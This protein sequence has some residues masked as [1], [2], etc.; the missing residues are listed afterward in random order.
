MHCDSDVWSLTFQCKVTRC[1]ILTTRCMHYLWD[2]CTQL[3]GTTLINCLTTMSFN[4]YANPGYP[5]L[6]DS[7]CVPLDVPVVKGGVAM[8]TVVLSSS[9]LSFPPFSL[10]TF[11]I[12]S[13]QLLLCSAVVLHSPPTLSRSLLTQSFLCILRHL[14]P[15]SVNLHSVPIL[16][17]TFPSFQPPLSRLNLHSHDS[18]STLPTQPPLSRLNLHSPDST[19]TLPTQSPLSRLNLHSPDSISTLHT[20]PPLSLLNIHSP[21]STSTLPTQHPLS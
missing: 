7:D 15:L 3:R 21:D 6:Q 20:Q 2:S 9:V 17:L 4:V 18:I 16:S 10:T 8:V 11:S 13:L 19:S 5:A 14:P 12:K 1:F